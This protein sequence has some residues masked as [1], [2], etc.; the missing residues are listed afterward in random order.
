LKI[1]TIYKKIID[2][3]IILKRQSTQKQTDLQEL[4]DSKTFKG[5]FLITI[6]SCGT[7]PWLY[8][9]GH[10]NRSATFRSRYTE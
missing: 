2:N 6:P 10:K 7:H 1:N 3:K 4:A 9:E 5:P 8:K